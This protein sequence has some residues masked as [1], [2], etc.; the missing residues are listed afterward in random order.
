M[1][2]DS[3]QSWLSYTW[4]ARDAIIFA[5]AVHAFGLIFCLFLSVFRD[6]KSKQI[7]LFFHCM[8]YTCRRGMQSLRTYPSAIDQKA[9]PV[10]PSFRHPSL[11][12]YN[13][14]LLIAIKENRSSTGES[15]KRNN[16][17]K[18]HNTNGIDFQRVTFARKTFVIDMINC[19][20]GRS[21][22][23]ML[24]ACTPR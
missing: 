16:A 6:I 22:R 5:V 21:E 9:M 7:Q 12:Q 19:P 13:E 14:I 11:V 20:S 3:F 18:Q 23:P 17:P 24:N 4:V 1:D 8:W 2:C 10:I 15:R